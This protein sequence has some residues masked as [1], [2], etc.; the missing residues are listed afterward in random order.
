VLS[1]IETHDMICEDPA[2]RAVLALL[3]RIAPSDVPVLITGETGTGKE[4]IAR[5]VHA[6]SQRAH[7]PFVAVNAGAFSETLIE[8]ELFG[9]ER[10][11]FTGAHSDKIGWFE[12]AD[13][14]TLFLDEIGELP[15]SMQVKLLRVLQEGVVTPLGARRP[16][17][18][19]VRIISATNVE[20][21][22][23]IAERRFREDLYYPL[24]VTS[25]QLPALRERPGDILPLARHFI[26]RHATIPDITLDSSA[27]E[28]L[29]AH[30]W[31]G[32]ARELENAIRRALL[33]R[34]GSTLRASDFA[35]ADPAADRADNVEEAEH[36]QFDALERAFLELMER[37][38]P[39]LRERVEATLLRS[40]Y[41]FS[42]RNQLETARMLGM[43]RHVVRARLI[44]HGELRDT[45]RA[46]K[47][48]RPAAEP[49]RI[50]YQKLGLL[51]LVKGCGSLDAAL[52]AQGVQVEWVEYAGGIQL[53]EALRTEQLSAAVL[54]DCPAVFAQAQDV[55][56]VYLAAEPPAPHGTALIVPEHSRL[57]EVAELRGRRVAVNRAAQAHYLLLRALEEA[58][59]PAGDVDI[60][61]E[62][63]DRALS[64][65]QRGEIDAW[66]IWD[67]WLSGA[68][69]DLRARVLR[70]ST[71][72]LKS[73]AYHVA[74]RDFAERH[75]HLIGELLTHLQLAAQWVKSDPV[76][77]S[78]LLAPGLGV[79]SRALVASLERELSTLPLSAELI[80]AQQDIADQALR[81]QLIPHAVTV[82]DALWNHSRQG[83]RA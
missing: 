36:K 77:I 13:G 8:S 2:S 26:A 18:V 31:P 65:F 82:A 28:R 56:I 62:P 30:S 38:A 53:V 40:A 3:Q 33:V 60:R 57:G 10:G 16:R 29:L 21:R 37:G 58:G 69:L 14:G 48:L 4:V 35:L 54:G 83:S 23:A 11:A 46:G 72:L 64:A 63:P 67:P 17:R 75:P 9:H 76:R 50:G 81:L 55:P 79:S 5:Q 66:A 59:V 44:A 71:G 80:A 78:A 12:A 20:L 68:R 7:K 52:Q 43:S 27:L 15:L 47:R 45:P 42:G 49:L 61:F 19:D 73:S 74:R 70:D 6:L 22:A 34:S 1:T 24:S 51:M 41:R 25:L 39:D 32:N